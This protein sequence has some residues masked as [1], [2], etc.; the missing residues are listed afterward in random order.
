MRTEPVIQACEFLLD[1]GGDDAW[2]GFIQ[3]FTRKKGRPY[4]K[5]QVGF[6]HGHQSD[7]SP[8]A[9]QARVSFMLDGKLHAF[10]NMRPSNGDEGSSLW[11]CEWRAGEP[12]TSEPN[13]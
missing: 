6:I 7:T 5:Q 9:T 10:S 11:W 13:A 12:S 3:G 1:N 2:A 4:V 8:M